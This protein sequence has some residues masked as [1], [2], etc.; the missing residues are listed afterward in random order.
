[1]L[2][3]VP[4]A[5][6]DLD[7]FLGDEALG[8]ACSGLGHGDGERTAL[9]VLGDRGRGEIGGGACTFEGNDHLR[10]LVLDRLEGA[11][12]HTELVT[13]LGVLEGEVEDR[14][15]GTDHL[16]GEGDR[17]LLDGTLDRLLRPHQPDVSRHHIANLHDLVLPELPKSARPTRS[18]PQRG[19]RR[20]VPHRRHQA[21]L[22]SA[23]PS[24]LPELPFSKPWPC[25]ELYAVNA[26][27]N[28]VLSSVKSRSTRMFVASDTSAIKSAGC[29]FVST[30]FFAASMQP[31]LALRKCALGWLE[32]V[33]HGAL[34]AH[35]KARDQLTIIRA[36]ARH[37]AIE[38]QI[39]A[40]HRNALARLQ[41][42]NAL[43]IPLALGNDAEQQH[44]G[45]EMGDRGSPG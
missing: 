8:V 25:P 36:L 42:D 24:A 39:I 18:P 37:H 38:G 23:A 9:V 7:A 12:G 5:A 20:L 45:G 32:H 17:R 13:F 33:D 43:G 44:A 31:Q 30:N 3:R 41:R 15:A 22:V 34:A 40:A 19:M 1:M 2:P 6:H 14:L 4:D 35:R 11:D 26:A 28:L 10:E 29:I 27:S 16:Q 21:P